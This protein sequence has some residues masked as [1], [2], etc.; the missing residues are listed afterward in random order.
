MNRFFFFCCVCTISIWSL[1]FSQCAFFFS[2]QHLR[3]NIVGEQQE[4]WMVWIWIGVFGLIWK[5]ENER[6]IGFLLF[7]PAMKRNELKV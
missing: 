1:F 3:L 4:T 2:C 6:V 7:Y 5:H